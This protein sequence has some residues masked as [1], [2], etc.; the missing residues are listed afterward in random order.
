MEENILELY[1][2][3]ISDLKKAS[4][5]N[6]IITIILLV[7]LFASNIAWLVYENQ[8]ETVADITS[9]DSGNGTATYLENSESGDITY[10]ENN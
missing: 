4:K 2:E 3:I 9:V 1:K 10:G 8:Y 5:R 6:F 7:M